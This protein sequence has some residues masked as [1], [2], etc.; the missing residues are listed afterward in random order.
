MHQRIRLLAVLTVLAMLTAACGGD[1][2]P[3]DESGDP[4]GSTQQDGGSNNH[5]DGAGGADSSGGSDDGSD[6]PSGS[7]DAGGAPTI[8]AG[9]MPAPGE[10]VFEVDGQTFT[11]KAEE[12]DY[13][14]CEIGADFVNVRSE[15]ATQ[16]LAV[17]FD[18]AA[19]L[20]NANVTPE[21]SDVRY[22]SFVGPATTGG[23]AAEDPYVLYE[24]R[25]DATQLDDISNLS[26]VGTGRV[27]VTCP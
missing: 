3:D 8:D 2:N 26:D 24:G 16:D 15:S 14:I 23:V 11:F 27:S 10:V 1:S 4:T 12:M 18:P 20:G 7:D 5:D 9:S 21:G 22:D 25:F 19:G 17:Q 13:F 6:D